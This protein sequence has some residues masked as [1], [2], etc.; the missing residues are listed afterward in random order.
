MSCHVALHQGVAVGRRASCVLRRNDAAAAADVVHHH[1][2]S[3]NFG[4]TLAKG[5]SHHVRTTASGHGHNVANGLVGVGRL[6]F[7]CGGQAQ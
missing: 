4:P 5:A 1:R 2:L 3:Q 6:R 7:A